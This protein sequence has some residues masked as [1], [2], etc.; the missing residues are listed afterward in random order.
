[1]VSGCQPWQTGGGR[2]RGGS[3]VDG[4]RAAPGSQAARTATGGPME[5]TQPR[6]TVGRRRARGP[7][8]GR[9]NA[10]SAS[11]QPP[12]RRR[13]PTPRAA[14]TAPLSR[15]PADPQAGSGGRP[16]EHKH[17]HRRARPRPVEPPA[18]AD[19]RRR[20]GRRRRRSPSTPRSS[21]SAPSRT[22]PRPASRPRPSAPRPS[23]RS[24]QS[25]VEPRRRRRDARRRRSPPTRPPPPA[26]YG[27]AAGVGAVIP[28]TFTGVVGEGK[29]GIYDVAVDGLAGET[30]I[31]VQ[32]GPAINGTDLRDATGEIKFG[33]FKNQIEYQNAGS[34][35][36][37]AMKKAVL[38]GI[39]T[40]SADRQDRLGRRRLHPGQSEELAGHAGG[41]RRSNERHAG[42][43][44][45]RRARSCSPRATSPSPTARSTRSRA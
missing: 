43:Q 21:A 15:G 30:Q 45:R 3:P 23:R 6:P 2:R 27:V 38:A 37:N 12:Q 41:D 44:P 33:Q 8:G 20:P 9:R 42:R 13:G 28:V 25:I 31:R 40:A 18:A 1:M 26:Q 17:R 5:E 4:K 36:N 29:S 16:H 34:A 14:S 10:P 24:R 35:I 7:G 19:R 11:D 39:D 22:S 32:T